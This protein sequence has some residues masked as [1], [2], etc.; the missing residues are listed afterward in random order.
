MKWNVLLCHLLSLLPL[1]SSLLEVLWGFECF[2]THHWGLSPPPPMHS[3]IVHN[4]WKFCSPIFTLYEASLIRVS[5]L[6][7][8][9]W[10][11]LL[12]SSDCYLWNPS[13]WECTR[14]E[15]WWICNE[16]RSQ[17]NLSSVKLETS[18]RRRLCSPNFLF[19]GAFCPHIRTFSVE[20]EAHRHVLDYSIQVVMLNNKRINI[21]YKA[22]NYRLQI[23]GYIKSNLL[24]VH[25][26]N[27]SI[28]IL[29]VLLII[30]H[31]SIK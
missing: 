6:A 28:Q 5:Y 31:Q 1:P 30:C 12:Q 7:D 13:A 27:N 29:F 14:M 4:L 11:T 10:N 16:T 25:V 22:L 18:G 8:G 23:V 26:F 3:P 20:G 24:K 2:I 9:L 21:L 15:A 19:D 17:I